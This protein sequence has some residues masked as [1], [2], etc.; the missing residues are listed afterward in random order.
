VS[1][2]SHSDTGR[3]V[4]VT[5][6]SSGIGREVALQLARRGDSVALLARRRAELEEVEKECFLAGSP[7]TVVVPADVSDTDAID[8]AFQR[9]A[10][11][12]GPID[13]V[14]HAAGVA[15]YGRFEE[16]SSDVFD[17]VQSVNVAGTAN[18][19]RAA[20][21]HFDGLGLRGNLVLVGSIVG[22]ISAP[23]LSPYVSSKWAVHG[24]AR[25]LQAEQGY[26]GHRISL[27]GPGGVDTSIYD[28]AATYLGVQGKPPP[29]VD[30]VKKV[31]RATVAMLDS[32]RKQRSVGAL[33]HFMSF[34][35]RALP[36]VY[37]LIAAP[38]MKRFALDDTPA[39]EHTGNLFEPLAEPAQS[40][41]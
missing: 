35:F 28:K 29:P 38:L 20:I 32:S 16:I 24:L 9:A 17:R 15:A 3:T 34:G 12:I 19:A 13:S 5:G 31:A 2:R 14:V 18:V 4:L 37:D 26:Q 39:A 22:R 8:A 33:N 30:D 10:E 36:A 40:G 27:V 25:S 6:A 41:R 7:R 1:S 23:F 21:R 11:E